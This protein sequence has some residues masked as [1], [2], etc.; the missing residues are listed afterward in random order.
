MGVIAITVVVYQCNLQPTGQETEAAWFCQLTVPE[1]Y[2]QS[3]AHVNPV[4]RRSL[5]MAVINIC[6]PQE[7]YGAKVCGM[8]VWE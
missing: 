5:S 1:T 7:F 4:T 6:L 3:T 2:A 8:H